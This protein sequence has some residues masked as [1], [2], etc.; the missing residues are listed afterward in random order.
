MK[1]GYN[2]RAG[3]GTLECRESFTVHGLW[4]NFDTG[5][6]P[7]FCDRRAHFDAAKVPRLKS[8]GFRP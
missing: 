2:T 4:I 1:Q 7:Q 5:R 8:L 6:Y 3:R